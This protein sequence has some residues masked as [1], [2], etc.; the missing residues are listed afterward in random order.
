MLAGIEVPTE[1]GIQRRPKPGLERKQRVQM[2]FQDPYAALNPF[3]RVSYT[4]TRLP[5]NYH[6]RSMS[7]AMNRARTLWQTVSL[8]PADESLKKRPR[9]LS[10][11]QPQRVVIA[12]M[13]AASPEIVIADEPVSMLDVS[14]RAV[15]LRVLR[16]RLEHNR[17]R[18]LYYPRFVERTASGS[19]HYGA[20]LGTRG[21]S[22]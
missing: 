21:G 3:N 16:D 12:R 10:G 4:I 9:Q 14:I 18:P 22:G 13:L 5:I 2:V 6:H 17:F 19:T 11:G 20:L 15:V 8:T 7:D 1:G